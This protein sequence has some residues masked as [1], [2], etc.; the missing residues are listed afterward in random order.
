MQVGLALEIGDST[1]GIKSGRH[2]ELCWCT[3]C[4]SWPKLRVWVKICGLWK[5][6]GGVGSGRLTH[7]DPGEGYE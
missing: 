6:L 3:R 7:L 4:V 1:G 5:V 2:R